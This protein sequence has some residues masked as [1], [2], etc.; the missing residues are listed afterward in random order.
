MKTVERAGASGY[1]NFAV[2]VY[3]R[4][5]E[6]QQMQDLAWLTPRWNVMSSHVKV[7]KIYLETHRDTR[8][9]DEATVA[10]AREFFEAR[11]VQAAGGI[12]LT[13]NESN[14]FET[15]C[16]TNPEHRA[17]VKAVAEHT[18]RLF[19]EV[20]LDDF[21]FTSC[22]CARCVL[23]KGQRSWTDFRL[24]LMQQSLEELVVKPS[25]AVNPSV[26][27][28]IKFPNWY[29]HFQ[30]LGYHLEAGP[31]LF[32]RIYTGTET[33]QPAYNPQHL[34]Q[35]HGYQIMRYFENIAP[36]RN[37]GG[38]VDP[39]GMQDAD[40]YAE[41]LWLTLF[42]KAREVTLFDFL[43]LQKPVL[44]TQRASWQ[45]QGTSFDF[46]EV[47]DP[48]RHEDG[49]FSADLSIARIAGAA[50]EQ[51]DRFLGKLGTPLGVKSYKPF[52]S[53]GDDFLHNYFGMIGVPIDLRPDFPADAATLFLTAAAAFDA[54]I[55]DKIE[56]HLGRGHQVFI[57]SGL[58]KALQGRGIADIAELRC[59]DRKVVTN[60]FH[61]WRGSVVRSEAPLTFP[62]LEYFTNDAWALAS[63][64][65]S[66]FPL[67]LQA[68]Y[69][70]GWL[71][72]LAVPDNPAD[73]YKLPTEMLNLLRSMLTAHLPLSIEGPS[74]VSLFPYDNDTFIV[75]SFRAEPVTIQVVTSNPTHQLQ[76]LI[77]KT[78]ITGQPR[79]LGPTGSGSAYDVQ[80]N[81]HSYRV[82]SYAG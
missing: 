76:D 17:K 82:F 78:I 12:T 79:A 67:I 8:V 66:S 65:A 36:G 60:E 58:L 81:P 20:I 64:D 3:A 25:K 10:T 47:T 43:N 39:F 9:A 45:G 14:R 37:G 68:S 77:T 44:P 23:A 70:T 71:N 54:D 74:Q 6:V 69:K 33:R 24:E 28:V 32:D 73:L 34:Q 80:L 61:R 30:G 40:R 26:Q 63:M 7:S 51:V 55:V 59:T 35:Y 75:E 53:Q 13:V 46:D 21:V 57:T 50:F 5:Y 48:Y 1:A 56:Q 2:A 31:K 72:V 42:A 15:F 49:S 19:D 18:A 22:K 38:W 52:H 16:Y 4:V 62:Q 29:E 41:Q 27:L 11:G